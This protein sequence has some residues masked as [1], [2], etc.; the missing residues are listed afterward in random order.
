MPHFVGDYGILL[1]LPLRSSQVR[2]L[3][4]LFFP[5]LVSARQTDDGSD[6]L[7]PK[8]WSRLRTPFRWTPIYSGFDRAFRS[9][10]FWPQLTLTTV[11]RTMPPRPFFLIV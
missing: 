5:F 6:V 8:V 4:V 7:D 9:P 1:R 11:L 2:F 3:P 10:S